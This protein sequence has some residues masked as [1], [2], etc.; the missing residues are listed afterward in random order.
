MYGPQRR[1][2]LFTFRPIASKQLNSLPTIDTLSSLG[3]AVV[4]HPL[5]EQEIPGSIPVSGKGFL[6]VMFCF[7]GVDISLLS[8]KHTFCHKVLQFLL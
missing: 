3:G 6:C 5:L 4:T 7:I 1:R 8:P 2:C